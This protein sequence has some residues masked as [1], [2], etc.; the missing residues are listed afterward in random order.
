MCVTR[1][2]YQLYLHNQDMKNNIH[3]DDISDKKQMQEQ[4]CKYRGECK[5]KGEL[6]EKEKSAKT[7]TMK[8]EIFKVVGERPISS[9]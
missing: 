8:N 1:K 3:Y 6:Y 5:N 7:T 9:R 4:H 2:N